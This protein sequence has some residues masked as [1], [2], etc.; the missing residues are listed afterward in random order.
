MLLGFAVGPTEAK[1]Q[2]GKR[3]LSLKRIREKAVLVWQQQHIFPKDKNVNIA[4]HFE[5]KQ[6]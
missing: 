4:L 1:N 5:V 3:W 2:K 6:T